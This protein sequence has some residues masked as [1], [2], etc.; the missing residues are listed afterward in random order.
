MA[1]TNI[2]NIINDNINNQKYNKI[3]TPNIKYIIDDNINY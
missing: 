3:T 1:T 2:K